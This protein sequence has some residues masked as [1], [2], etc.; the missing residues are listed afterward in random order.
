MWADKLKIPIKDMRA[1]Y[2]EAYFDMAGIMNEPNHKPEIK[3][4]KG[5]IEVVTDISDEEFIKFRDLA[6]KTCPIHSMLHNA[7]VDIKVE[8]Q[9][10]D[11]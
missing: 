5:R 1:F 6:E 11:A 9:K 7:G 4:I 10:V 8:W 3:S 2:D